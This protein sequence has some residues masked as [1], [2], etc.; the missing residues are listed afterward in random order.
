[1]A[2]ISGS[3]GPAITMTTEGRRGGLSRKLNLVFVTVFP[4]FMQPIQDI[5][6]RLIGFD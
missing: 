5:R 1:M 4:W 2:A 6:I 3:D